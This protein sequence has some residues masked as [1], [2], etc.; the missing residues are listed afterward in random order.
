MPLI[1]T[2]R[3]RRL[4]EVEVSVSGHTNGYYVDALNAADKAFD[5]GDADT[6]TTA[7]NTIEMTVEEL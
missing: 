2:F 4:Q 5:T 7:P 3:V 1:R 6:G